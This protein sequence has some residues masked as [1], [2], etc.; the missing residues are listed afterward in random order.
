MNFSNA[1]QIFN[2]KLELDKKSENH[3]VEIYNG[4]GKTLSAKSQQ[5]HLTKRRHKHKILNSCKTT[6]S[7]PHNEKN[8]T[9]VV[10][11]T[12]NKCKD[13]R[14]VVI[15]NKNGILFENGRNTNISKNKIM[16]DKES[17]CYERTKELTIA[18]KKK[19]VL[20]HIRKI[21]FI[22]T[23]RP[24]FLKLI[25]SN[26]RDNL[27]LVVSS[28]DPSPGAKVSAVKII[29]DI[30]K[31]SYNPEQ[32]NRLKCEV[33]NKDII[34]PNE[35]IKAPKHLFKREGIIVASGFFLPGSNTGEISFI[36]L[37]T[38][39][40]TKITQDK[41]NWFYHRVIPT[42]FDGIDGILTARSN[43]GF[44]PGRSDGELVFLTKSNRPDGRWNEVIIAK[45]PDVH[46]DLVDLNDDGRNQI[47][48]G[49]F[50]KDELNV[51]WRENG[52]FNKVI[53]DKK[54]GR[55]F[56]VEVVKYLDKKVLLT[57]NHKNKGSVFMYE[58]PRDFK[59][60]KWKKHV[61][62]SDIKT[63]GNPMC[64]FSPGK[65]IPIFPKQGMKGKPNILVSGDGSRKVHLL[66]PQKPFDSNDF[67]YDEVILHESKSTVGSIE[68]GHFKGDNSLKAF[69][70]LY[71]EDKILV[72]SFK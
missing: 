23:K 55:P 64:D 16:N 43:K 7:H 47:V 14:R 45:G 30:D 28:F 59:N 51:I 21:G 42:R 31:F 12:S 50:F 65:A 52:K 63:K 62:L 68:V 61:I 15:E 25:K 36:D 57:T 44:L 56:D 13:R 58:I 60:D 70:P 39:Q 5:E 4:G 35:V 33:L 2:Y 8:L 54:I 66:I 20:D 27:D 3:T 67:G 1:L 53:I 72:L 37:E 71:E 29:K 6:N 22:H 41:Q 46:F 49:E 18:D 38:K 10:N 24:A 26:S 69:I 9:E 34:W 32:L 11:V 48:V 40:K 19:F 17:I